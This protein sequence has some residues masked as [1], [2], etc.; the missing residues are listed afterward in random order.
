MTDVAESDRK[1]L[2]CVQSYEDKRV[3][4]FGPF[5]IPFPKSSIYGGWSPQLHQGEV[6]TSSLRQEG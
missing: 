6:G 5:P 3:A 4:S 1:R 2:E